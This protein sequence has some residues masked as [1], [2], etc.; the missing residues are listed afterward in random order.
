[1]RNIYLNRVATTTVFLYHLIFPE[2]GA[3]IST[4]GIVGPLLCGEQFPHVEF[5]NS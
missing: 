4:L 5:T 3:T 1:M 2:Q